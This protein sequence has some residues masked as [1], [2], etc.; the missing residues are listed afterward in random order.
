VKKKD[1][2]YL[3][4]EEKFLTGRNSATKWLYKKLPAT[5]NLAFNFSS[6]QGGQ[7]RRNFFA[8]KKINGIEHFPRYWHFRRY[9]DRN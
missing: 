1:A 8:K 6:L 3:Y 9:G 5:K 7:Y 2:M 4:F